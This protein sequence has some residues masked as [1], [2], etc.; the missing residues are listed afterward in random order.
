MYGDIMSPRPVS[1]WPDEPVTEATVRDGFDENEASGSSL[2]FDDTIFGVW[3]I[4][5]EGTNRAVTSRDRMAANAVVDI[6]FETPT[7]YRMY[8][9]THHNGTMQWVKYDIEEKGTEGGDRLETTLSR[10]ALLAGES[11]L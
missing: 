7:A 2:P 8:S 6:V 4:T 9:Y 10:Y 5:Q 1:N 3:G 11:D